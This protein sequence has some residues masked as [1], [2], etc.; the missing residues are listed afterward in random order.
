MSPALAYKK[1]SPLIGNQAP[2]PRKTKRKPKKREVPARRISKLKWNGDRFKKGFE[3]TAKLFLVAA[4][5]YGIFHGYRFLTT[6][7]QFALSQV[8]FSGNQVLEQKQL[9]GWADPLI[10]HNIFDL[11]LAVVSEAVSKNPWVRHVA[12]VRKFP[13]TL[14]ILLEEREPYA[15]IQLDR[16]Y[17][18]DNFGVLIAP[19]REK[20]H[21]LP[22][23]TGVPTRRPELGQPMKADGIV[24]GLQAM[25]Y[26]NRLSFFQ[27]DPIDQLRLKG[28]DQLEFTTRHQ[29]RKIRMTVDRIQEGFTNFKTYLNAVGDNPEGI[30]TIDLSFKNQVVIQPTSKSKSGRSKRRT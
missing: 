3:I 20:D 19:A 30:H 27:K 17:I 11:D 9:K 26:L 13:Q 21:P 24:P 1:R 22:L 8:V 15:R 28:F 14:H 16:V 6:A 10:G 29:N 25:H 4:L 5:G 12:V 2:V 7:P 18:M 23:I